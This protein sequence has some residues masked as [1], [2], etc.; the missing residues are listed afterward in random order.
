M[1]ADCGGEICIKNEELGGMIRSLSVP[2]AGPPAD[3]GW[4]LERHVIRSLA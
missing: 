1:V 2:H 3:H 4:T